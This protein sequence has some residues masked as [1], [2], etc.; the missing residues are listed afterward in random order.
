MLTGKMSIER[1]R[2]YSIKETLAL[3]GIKAPKTLRKYAKAGAIKM[4]VHP[5]TGK[6]RYR[7]S[8][9]EKFFNQRI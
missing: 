6:I 8:E 5:A 3:L 9:I 2:W 1:D 4:D 7:G